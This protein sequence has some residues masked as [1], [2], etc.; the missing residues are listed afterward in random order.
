MFDRHVIGIEPDEPQEH[1]TV[2]LAIDEIDRGRRRG[3]L[4]EFPVVGH[5]IDIFDESESPTRQIRLTDDEDRAL[6]D[7]REHHASVI[8]V[9]DDETVS[10]AAA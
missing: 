10:D 9:A 7:D 6:G 4:Q 5:R 3:T 2:R 8:D 1:E